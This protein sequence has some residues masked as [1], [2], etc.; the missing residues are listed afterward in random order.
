MEFVSIII[1]Y[2]NFKAIPKCL[3]HWK[4][5]FEKFIGSS[6]N[7]LSYN[8]ILTRVYMN[9]RRYLPLLLSALE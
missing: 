3:Y 5:V 6:G 9:I 7:G 2:W 4:K 8:A 1:M